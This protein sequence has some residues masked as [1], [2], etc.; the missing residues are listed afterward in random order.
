[1]PTFDFIP[2]DT[3]FFR[4][5]RPLAAGSS[6]GRGAHW[7]LPTVLHAA[8]RTAM[9]R[10]ADC[11]PS[12]KH[13]NGTQ[14]KGRPTGKI[15]TD[16]FQWLNLRGPFPVDGSGEV[17]FPMPRDLVPASKAADA[18][19]AYMK[20]VKNAL[21]TNNLPPPLT[22]L[23]ASFAE[24]SKEQLADWVPARFYA[25]Y[26]AGKELS[27]PEP[28]QLWD[29]EHRIGVALEDD[30][31][32]SAESQLYAAEHLRLRKDVR[33][34]FAVADP[35]N[36]KPRLANEQGKTV[37]DL[38]QGVI[39]LGGEQRFGQ[40]TPANLPLDLPRFE[41]NS[42][43]VKW[44]LLTP[45][46]FC[47]GW[48]PGW[49]ADDGE[50]KLRVVD[51]EARRDFRRRRREADWHYDE[52]NDPAEKIRATLVAACVGKPQP[53]GGWELLH[54]IQDEQGNRHVTGGGKPTH[55]AV[56]SGSVY[57]FR[58]LGDSPEQRLAEARKLARALQARCRSDYF[59]EKGLGLGVCGTW[60]HQDATSAD[61]RNTNTV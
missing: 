25:D 43:L 51:K 30:T 8:L 16:A 48:R 4:D 3:L 45:A 1:M 49:I 21:G 52:A 18:T 60:A 54:E 57:Y 13:V 61:V 7:P 29:T 20:V 14:R 50:V 33:L 58:A 35:P 24:P 23:V 5:G 44:V 47:H 27:R 19:P 41:I 55:L 15:G 28:P 56:P 40:L 32:T 9:L 36:H 37:A 26:L 59:G 6:F 12:G 11:L 46:I 42:P 34:R 2:V 22:C 10:A 53:V 17:F 38:A 39:S 31:H